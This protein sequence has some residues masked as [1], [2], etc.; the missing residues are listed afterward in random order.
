MAR[1]C[2]PFTMAK[3]RCFDASEIEAAKAWV[4]EA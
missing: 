3:T 1:A 2:K 4:A